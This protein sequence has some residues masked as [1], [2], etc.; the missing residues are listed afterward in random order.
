MQTQAF[1]LFKLAGCLA[2]QRLSSIISAFTLFCSGDLTIE[3]MEINL[4]ANGIV[5]L[6][7]LTCISSGGPA[8]MVTWTR[9]SGNGTEGTETVLDDRLTSQ[10]SHTLT[11][12][13]SSS[14]SLAYICE[15][16]NN[17]PSSATIYVE[18]YTGSGMSIHL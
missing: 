9:D 4:E 10:Y 15:V 13:E 17:K 1:G 16:S 18:I 11:V 5:T 14:F 7:T 2:A 12:T 8:T 3:G 6:F